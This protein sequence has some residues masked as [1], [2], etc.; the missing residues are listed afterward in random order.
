MDFIHYGKQTI[1]RSDIQ[2]VIDALTSDFLTQG[3]C[4]P[5]FENLLLQY[6]DARYAVAVS[7]ATAALHLSCL[8]L[9]V[10]EGDRVWTS[11]ITFVASSNAALLCRATV[12]FVDIDPDTY[13]MSVDVLEEKLIQAK[14]KN[15]LPK[16]VI[17]VHFSGQSCDMKRIHK[18]SLVYG[19]KILEDASHAIGAFYNEKRVGCCEYSD[20]AVFSF[21]PVKI[22]TTGEGGAITTNN[23]KTLKKLSLLK[24][25]GIT[26]DSNLLFR[27]NEGSWYYEQ[28]MLGLNYR[29]T[30][31]QCALGYSQLLRIDDFLKIRK[32]IVSTYHAGLA[33]CPIK[34][35]IVR[36]NCVSSWHLYCIQTLDNNRRFVFDE[37]LK[38]N[39][40]VNV[41]YI[42]VHFQP[43]YKKLG[44]KPGDFP[45][46]ES[47]YKNAITLPLHPGLSEDQLEYIIT[48]LKKVIYFREPVIS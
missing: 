8:A 36:E 41:H 48:C 14:K 42:P 47:Y 21:H 25:H 15:K 37:L 10:S 23:E 38:N 43:Y 22:I 19:F 17:P 40:G 5:K 3:P 7:N 24:T 44:F 6:V 18:L 46:S 35:P 34:L 26:R 1:D 33:E 11:P 16:L 13:N 9:G 28:V 39:I 32:K 31:I 4:I 2:A 30:D 20:A 27:K 29:I 45:V 12:D